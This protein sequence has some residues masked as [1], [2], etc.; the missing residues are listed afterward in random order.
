MDLLVNKFSGVSNSWNQK[1][2]W[3]LLVLLKIGGL[4]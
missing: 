2:W 3:M 1:N 4:E